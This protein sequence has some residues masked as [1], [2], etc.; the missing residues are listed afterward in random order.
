MT[1]L[2][3]ISNRGVG[4]ESSVGCTGLW[5]VCMGAT[6]AW[7]KTR[8]DNGACGTYAMSGDAWCTRAV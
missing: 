1:L 2:D 7:D 5:G 8:R 6:G 4:G 3:S